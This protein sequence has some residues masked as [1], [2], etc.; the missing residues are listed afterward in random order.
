MKKMLSVRLAGGRPL[1]N[2]VVAKAMPI[3]KT[4]VEAKLGKKLKIGVDCDL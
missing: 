2:G 4:T 3:V 1:A